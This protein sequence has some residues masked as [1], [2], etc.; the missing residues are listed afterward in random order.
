MIE[1]RVVLN[2]DLIIGGGAI[3]KICKNKTCNVYIYNKYSCMKY[4]GQ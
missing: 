2:W 1:L 3:Q 4:C